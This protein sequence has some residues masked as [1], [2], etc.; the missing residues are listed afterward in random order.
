MKFKKPLQ[1]LCLLSFLT[2]SGCQKASSNGVSAPEGYELTWSDEFDGEELD[3]TNWTPLIGNGSGGWGNNELEYYQ[4]DNATVQDGVLSIEARKESVG[5][6][7]YTSS[8]LVSQRKVSTTYGYIEARIKLPAQNAMW[9]AFWM[10]PENGSWPTAG[11]IDIMENKAS[12]PWTTS[13]ALHYANAGGHTYVYQAHA[14]SQRNGDKNI[15]EWHTYAV[16]WKEE[17][18]D[19]YVDGVSFFQVLKRVWHPSGS[20]VYTGDDSAPFNAPF[21]ILLNLAVG[22][23]F[24]SNH[25]TPDA[26]FESAT[27]QVDYVRIFEAK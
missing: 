24:D 7:S 14:F 20:T 15:E 2:V 4:K 1:I 12:S 25:T 11:E 13:G 18:I 21:H 5:G 6:C 17:E 19:W 22:G 9:P 16:E 27:M 8:R 26:S 10:L 23:N 3:S